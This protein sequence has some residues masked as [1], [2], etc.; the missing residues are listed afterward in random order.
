MFF[1]R[2]ISRRISGRLFSNAW[3]PNW[4]LLGSSGFSQLLF[5]V[6]TKAGDL[7]SIGTQFNS[8]YSTSYP[9][10]ELN[11]GGLNMGATVP[12]INNLT[13]T[14]TALV[15]AKSFVVANTSGNLANFA[16]VEMDDA[17]I[18]K[19]AAGKTAFG[20][21]GT[22]R[23]Q[24]K[25]PCCLIKFRGTGRGR[26]HRL[27]NV[28]ELQWRH[29]RLGA[30]GLTVHSGTVPNCGQTIDLDVPLC[31]LLRETRRFFCLRQSPEPSL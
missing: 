21:C 5:A 10:S 11:P 17:V 19:A 23:T 24:F 29:S 26:L 27:W 13:P 28:H 16:C 31:P 4:T 15:T 8:F 9:L 20:P 12:A 6:P 1:T 14:G 7:A 2:P 22:S 3:K 30:I 18:A 25:M